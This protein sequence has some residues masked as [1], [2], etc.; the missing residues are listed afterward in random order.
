MYHLLLY[1]HHQSSELLVKL[2]T[3]KANFQPA[4]FEYNAAASATTSVKHDV[5]A[6]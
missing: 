1:H 5:Q 6:F 2:P 4:F 3:E